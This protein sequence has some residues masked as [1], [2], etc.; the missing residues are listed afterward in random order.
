M[1]ILT[2]LINFNDTDGVGVTADLLADGAGNLFGTATSGG[3]N[4]NSTVFEI[5]KVDGTYAS[6]PTTL[7]SFNGTNGANPFAGLIADAAG[8][9]FGTT[10]SGGTNGD[11]TVFEIANVDGSYASTPTMLVSFNGTNGSTPFGGLIEDAAGNLFG[12]TQSGGTNDKG[13]VFGDRQCRRYIRQYAD[14][15]GQLQRHQWV[16][17]FGRSDSRRRRE[18]VRHDSV[19]WHE[20]Q[21]HSI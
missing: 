9:L 13:T 4:S 18:P 6:T 11:G 1:P 16:L 15:T 2:T 21:W 10:Q 8:N 20:R 19:W 5:A 17:P 14:H 3:T 12:T 7:V